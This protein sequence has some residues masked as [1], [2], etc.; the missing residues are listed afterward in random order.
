[1]AH[2]IVGL[3]AKEAKERARVA[4][5]IA[6]DG[7]ATKEEAKEDARMVAVVLVLDTAIVLVGRTR[8]RKIR[9]KIFVRISWHLVDVAKEN[10]ASGS[11]LFQ[12]K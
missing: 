8:G 9:I 2:R 10:I 5:A 3:P 12:M 6:I 4:M 11:I 7:R 1:M